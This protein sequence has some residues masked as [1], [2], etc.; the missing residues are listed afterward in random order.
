VT[1]E[2]KSLLDEADEELALM[3]AE[4]AD[5]PNGPMS[6]LVNAA[7]VKL[8]RIEWL[9]KNYLPFHTLTIVDGDSTVGKSL[10]MLDL[11]ARMSSDTPM[12]D[13]SEA[14]PCVII[15]LNKEDHWGRVITPRLTAAGWDE[16]ANRVWFLKGKPK[17]KS[18]WQSVVLPADIDWLAEKIEAAKKASGLDRVMFYADPLM[19]VIEDRINSHNYHEMIR[20]LEP[21][22]RLCGDTGCAFVGIRHLTKSNPSG[23]AIH[24][25][26]GSTAIFSTSRM[27]LMVAYDPDDQTEEEHRARLLLVNGT[28]LGPKKK[29]LRWRLDVVTV[30]TEDGPTEAPRVRWEGESS[31]T[32]DDVAALSG[33]DRGPATVVKAKMHSALRQGP[34]LHV[35][36]R[37]MVEAE[38][39]ASESTFWRVIRQETDGGRILKRREGGNGLVWY[40][41]PIHEV[42]L[43]A[44][45]EGAR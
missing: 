37:E 17:G 19:A 8:E 10:T 33:G 13:G 16:S 39:T 31:V 1:A 28:N 41:L 40:A 34:M 30:E 9:W 45:T 4:A 11:I 29:S 5:D 22:H 7:D 26:Q 2:R 21:I 25:G 43:V 23:K 14:E 12:P 6:G 3:A 15:V 44:L 18:Q 35:K 38:T 27:G 24:G 20:A 32:A 36:L 42:D